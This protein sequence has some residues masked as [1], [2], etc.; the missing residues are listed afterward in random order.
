MGERQDRLR[1]TIE[2]QADE[3]AKLGG[4]ASELALQLL[5]LQVLLDIRGLLYQSER[6]RTHKWGSHL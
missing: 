4:H 3:L 1:K 2:E 6:D 5:I